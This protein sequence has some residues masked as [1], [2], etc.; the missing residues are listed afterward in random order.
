MI[1]NI[2]SFIVFTAFSATLVLFSTSY[3]LSAS[4]VRNANGEITDASLSPNCTVTPDEVYFPIYKFGLCEEVPTYLNYMTACKFLYDSTTGQTVAVTSSSNF[5]LANNISISEGSYK[6]AVVLIGNTIG[7]LHNDVFAA[8]W[9]GLE[10]NGGGGYSVTNGK[11]CSTRLDSGSEDDFDSNL[12]CAN[13][14]LAGGI[15][16]ET[17]GAYNTAGLGGRCSIAA[18]AISSNLTFNTASG[19]TTV[20]GMLDASTLETYTGSDTDATRQLVTQTFATAVKISPNTT[21]LNLAFKVTDML[22]I[23]DVSGGGVDYIQAY[24]DGFEIA[25]DAN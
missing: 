6:A 15:F 18:G 3:L 21:S 8:P 20:C 23:E 16:S 7:V 11:Y 4:C 1:A 12:D 19:S 13:S 10:K 14:A 22:S 24:L 2:K 17:D 5:Q 25:I 9:D